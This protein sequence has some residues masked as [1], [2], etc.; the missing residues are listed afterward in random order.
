[1]NLINFIIE[2]SQKEEREL[3]EKERQV[4]K[5]VLEKNIQIFYGLNWM[6]V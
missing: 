5:E 6:I 4:K 2:I 1:M 3:S